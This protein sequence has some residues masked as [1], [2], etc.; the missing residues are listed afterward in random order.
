MPATKISFRKDRNHEYDFALSRSLSS[1]CF[2]C[3]SAAFSVVTLALISLRFQTSL[4][5]DH[6]SRVSPITRCYLCTWCMKAPLCSHSTIFFSRPPLPFTAARWWCSSREKRKTTDTKNQ[7][8]AEL[9]RRFQSNRE[10]QRSPR[11]HKTIHPRR[12]FHFS[13]RRTGEARS[14]LF[15]LKISSMGNS[16]ARRSLRRPVPLALA[17]RLARAEPRSLTA[18]RTPANFGLRSARPF[19]FHWNNIFR[20]VW[21]SEIFTC[22]HS[23]ST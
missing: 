18:E 19:V 4:T 17:P 10:R 6:D 23:V 5:I 12:R 2:A 7:H 14:R 20:R 16:L 21:I 11:Y 9:E 3:C 15:P 1:L 22:S 8:S 13:F